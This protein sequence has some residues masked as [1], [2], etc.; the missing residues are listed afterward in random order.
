M[1][2][3]HLLCLLAETDFV[4]EGLKIKVLQSEQGRQLEFLNRKR[5]ERDLVPLAD[6]CKHRE[7]IPCEI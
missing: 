2:L 7:Q 5:E 1:F 6:F 3:L 4:L